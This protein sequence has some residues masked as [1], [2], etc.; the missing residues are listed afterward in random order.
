M[1]KFE[2]AV[3]SGMMGGS[4][5]DL[6]ILGEDLDTLNLISEDLTKKIKAIPG[7]R[8]IEKFYGRRVTRSSSSYRS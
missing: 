8:E 3:E 2:V 7:T 1:L 4:M 5:I 6:K